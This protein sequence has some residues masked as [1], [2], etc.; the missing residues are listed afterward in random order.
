MLDKDANLKG[1]SEYDDKIHRVGRVSTIIV[2]IALLAVPISLTIVTGV[3]TEFG[4]T[5]NAFLSTFMLFGIVGAVEFFTFAPILGAG[6]QYLSFITGNILAMKIPAVVSGTK[7]AGYEPGTPEADAVS[8]ISAAVSSLVT[9]LILTIGM[10]LAV[11]L[12]PILTHE[13]LAPAFAQIM[14]AIMGA[15]SAPILLKDLKAASV[16][17]ILA[18]IITLLLGQSAMG[19]LQTFLIPIF[20]VLAVGWKFLLTKIKM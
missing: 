11:P 20:L 13:A 8:L 5:V 19:Q 12:M 7:L 18:I 10:L 3:S 16:P 15:L 9:M 2:V 14:P 6:A 17:C 1:M 4:P